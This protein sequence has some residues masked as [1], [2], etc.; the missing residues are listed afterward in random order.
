MVSWRKGER[1]KKKEAKQKSAQRGWASERVSERR[2]GCIVALK[3]QPSEHEDSISCQGDSGTL[4]RVLPAGSPKI[5]SFFFIYT[6][7]PPFLFFF[8][9]SVSRSCLSFLTSQPL[10]YLPAVFSLL[11]LPGPTTPP[12]SIPHLSSLPPPPH[13]PPTPS[14]NASL[15]TL[16]YLILSF[17]CVSSLPDFPP[18]AFCSTSPPQPPG[19]CILKIRLPVFFLSCHFQLFT[20]YIF[21]APPPKQHKSNKRPAIFMTNDETKTHSAS[22]SSH[23]VISCQVPSLYRHTC[24]RHIKKK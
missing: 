22:L 7:A 8:H 24:L 20:T 15:F 14:A 11:T 21:P 18:H 13:Q 23:L 3:E 17:P 5:A 9:T 4:A 12:P 2:R 6:R 16:S 1:E 19:L 10:Y